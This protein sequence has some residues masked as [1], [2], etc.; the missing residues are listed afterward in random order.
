MYKYQT[1]PLNNTRIFIIYFLAQ[2]HNVDQSRLIL[3]G[4]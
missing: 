2:Q 4:L 1:N 3:W